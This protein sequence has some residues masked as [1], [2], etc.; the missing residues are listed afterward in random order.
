MK[1]C[2]R[3][4]LLLVFALCA[5]VLLVFGTKGYVMYR[6]ATS[7]GQIEKKVQSVRN[8]DRYTVTADLPPI[9]LDAVIA[10]EDHRFFRHSGIDPTAIA[11]AA[12][13]DLKACRFVEGGSTI[14]QQLAKN[15]FFTQ[16]KK[17]ERKIAE[18][19]AAF[20]L[21]K[22]YAKEEILE[23]Y[24]NTIYYGNGWY[25]IRDASLGY[26]G[27]EPGA[28]TDAECTLLAGIPNAPS[29]YAPTSSPELAA[30]RQRQVLAKMVKYGRLTQ[31][32]ADAILAVTPKIQDTAKAANATSAASP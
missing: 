5:C 4:M 3:R 23:L 15:L 21:E 25:R 19:F 9:Y 8:S 29:A 28:M 32:R 14:T 6:A 20:A 10:V 7:E 2:I 17:I 12:W 22:R 31:A 30:Q 1:T 24:V 11:R 18:V 27:K 16:E 13:H 26:Y